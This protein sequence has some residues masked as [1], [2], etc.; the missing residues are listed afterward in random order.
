MRGRGGPCPNFLFPFKVHFWSIK[1]VYFL[2]D[3]NNF[4]IINNLII[5]GNLDKIQKNSNFFYETLAWCSTGP[6]G[7][8]PTCPHPSIPLANDNVF[9][10][11]LQLHLR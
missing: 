5:F 2:Q 11:T 4:L 6:W 8:G 10:E 1:G 9:G 3:A 7:A